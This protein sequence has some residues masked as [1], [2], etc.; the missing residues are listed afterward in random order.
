[1]TLAQSIITLFS[2]LRCVGEMSDNEEKYSPYIALQ[3]ANL[4][5]FALFSGFI[6]ATIVMVLAQYPNV[7]QLQAQAAL[8]VLNFMLDLFL[9]LLLDEQNTLSY[10]VTVA[11]QLPPRVLKTLRYRGLL[12]NGS[13]ILLTM[14]VPI[15][16]LLWNLP[17]LA[18]ASILM[19]LA[20]VVLGFL[21][22]KPYWDF[23][24]EHPLVRK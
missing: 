13:W 14:I 21:T 15:L 17:Y 11:P 7:A 9:Y 2:T 20:W 1:M 22:V 4:T 18:L 5:V 16:F 8:F 10:C 19:S 12:L 6:F 23:R 24:R 3:K